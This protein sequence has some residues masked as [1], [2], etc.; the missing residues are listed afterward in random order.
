MSTTDSVGTVK[1]S[2][3]PY[4]MY[5]YPHTTLHTSLGPSKSN[6]YISARVLRGQ[7]GYHD[8]SDTIV[9]D[10]QVTPDSPLLRQVD[11]FRVMNSANNTTNWPSGMARE[12]RARSTHTLTRTGN[13]TPPPAPVARV[14]PPLPRSYSPP[15]RPTPRRKPRVIL[16]SARLGLACLG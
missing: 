15:P 13:R 9:G 5:Q 7:Y 2:C 12:D 8:D 3:I 10:N 1:S 14:T 6:M 16:G 4:K 11:P